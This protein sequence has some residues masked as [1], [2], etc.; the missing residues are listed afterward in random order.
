MPDARDERRHRPGPGR[1]WLEWWELVFWAADA[2][3]GGSVRLTL[4]PGAMR[5]WLWSDLLGRGRPLVTAR[6]DE[7]ALPRSDALEVRAEGLWSCLTCETPMEHW[8][9]GLEAFAVALEDPDEAVAGA[10]GDRVPMGID[11][12][13]EADGPAEDTLAL[14]LQAG[15]RRYEQPASVHGEVLI[16]AERLQLDCAGWRVRGWGQADWSAAS[17]WTAARVGPG[18]GRA[19]S[20]SWTGEG[21]AGSGGETM[22]VD[23]LQRAPI[24]VRGPRP[25]VLGRLERSLCRVR[26][27]DGAQGHGWTESFLPALPAAGRVSPDE[28]P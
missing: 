8:S 21:S 4:V 10:R 5:A 22:H 26:D 3:L 27:R 19:L 13:W 17:G 28:L 18:P 9:V 16:G 2:S 15:G 12:E 24:D 20:H 1:Q 6:D 7:V 11:L 14:G 23:P 25:A